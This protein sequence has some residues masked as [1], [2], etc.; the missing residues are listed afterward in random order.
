MSTTVEFTAELLEQLVAK[1]RS[2]DEWEAL[3][4]RLHKAEAHRQEW[5]GDWLLAGEEEYGQKCYDAA[6]EIF[7]GDYSRKHLYN[8]AYVFKAVPSSLRKENLRFNHY[9]AVAKLPEH[10]KRMWLEKAATENIPAKEL[11]RLINPPEAK[12]ER[13]SMLIPN[14]IWDALAFEGNPQEVAIKILAV[15]SEGRPRLEKPPTDEQPPPERAQEPYTGE[16]GAASFSVN[17]FRQRLRQINAGAKRSAAIGVFDFVR[18]NVQGNGRAELT[19]VSQDN[20][21]IVVLKEVEA[22]EPFAVLINR[23]ELLEAVHALE[24]KEF[25]IRADSDGVKLEAALFS[26]KFSS[27]HLEQFRLLD[28]P[29]GS[30]PLA[31]VPLEPLQKAAKQIIPIL[32]RGKGR[33]SSPLARLELEDGA[34]KLLTT[35][36]Y[37]FG[38]ASAKGYEYSAAPAVILPG[39]AL[40]RIQKLTGENVK[41]TETEAGFFFETQ[42]ETL[43]TF[44]IQGEFPPVEQ[45]IA[46]AGKTTTLKINGGMLNRVLSR[47]GND[48]GAQVRFTYEP[49]GCEDGLYSLLIEGL[50]DGK[51]FSQESLEIL[52]KGEPVTWLMTRSFLNDL[53]DGLLEVSLTSAE[54]M[55]DFD[56]KGWRLLIMPCKKETA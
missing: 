22:S 2:F 19:R 44:K 17:E 50:L 41:I 39:T 43:Y 55:I 25:I 13:H 8:I 36:G 29:D 9:L 31:T 27:L 30:E 48:T 52:G 7:K 56:S 14:E 11:R 15:W 4:A 35:D 51:P 40:A 10:E 5:I 42:T 1:S 28:T 47:I 33:Y 37:R 38:I 3:G 23:H 6:A 46:A 32:P 54:K 53:G 49:S 26:T 16:P 18:L 20:S 45:V 24:T 34:L 12:E 21:L